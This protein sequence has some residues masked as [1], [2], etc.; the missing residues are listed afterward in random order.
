M[1]C[2]QYPIFINSFSKADG[3]LNGVV[4]FI[5]LLIEQFPAFSH[6][7]DSFRVLKQPGIQLIL[8]RNLVKFDYGRKKMFLLLVIKY[9]FPNFDRTFVPHTG[10]YG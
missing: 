9:H 2:Q 3:A 7:V 10:K 6:K 8:F 5:F 1:I 4:F